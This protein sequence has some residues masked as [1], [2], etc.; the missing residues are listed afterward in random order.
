MNTAPQV[1]ERAHLQ[2]LF[3]YFSHL[4]LSMYVYELPSLLFKHT[5]LWM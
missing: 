3:R 2:L 5:T 4:D 1:N